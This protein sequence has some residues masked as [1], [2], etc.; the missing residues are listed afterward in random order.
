MT[1][2]LDSEDLLQ[3]Y[4]FLDMYESSDMFLER[5]KETLEYL[6]FK[7]LKLDVA[8]NH[9]RVSICDKAILIKL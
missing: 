5:K 8:L 7:L 2:L 4:V 9:N 6:R 3:I 1:L